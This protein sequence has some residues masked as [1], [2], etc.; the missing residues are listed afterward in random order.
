MT[1]SI[2]LHDAQA[3]R[4]VRDQLTRALL[5]DV[6]D[7]FAKLALQVMTSPASDDEQ[8]VVGFQT[9]E[10]SGERQRRTDDRARRG[11]PG[12]R[13]SGSRRPGNCS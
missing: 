13:G 10:L 4:A 6:V 2:E 7:V 9:E 1:E 12:Q 11:K 5:T 3:H 8:E